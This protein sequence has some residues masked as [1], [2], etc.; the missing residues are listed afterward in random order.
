MSAHVC[1]HCVHAYV[2]E[3]RKH[4]KEAYA[5]V[6]LQ[7]N[8][9]VDQQKRFYDRA[10]STTQLMPGDIVL[11]KLDMFQGKRKVK[12]QWREVEYVVV[13]QV[14]DIDTCT[15]GKIVMDNLQRLI[16]LD[17]LNSTL[18]SDKCD[19]LFPSNCTNLN[20]Q[21]YNLIV[22]QHNVRSLLGNLAE[23]KQLLQTLHDKNSPVD[24]LLL[25][26]T[27]LTKNVGLVSI[28][29]SVK[30]STKPQGWWNYNFNKGWDSLQMKARPRR[31]YRKTYR[32]NIH[33]N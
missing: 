24:L 25:C 18:W 27:F 6:H 4:F 22:L 31:I 32:I 21:N 20:P 33:R 15:K 28:L 3:V 11:M 26:E 14:A 8:S 7:T 5:E 29:Y 1:S 12:D 16:N 10:T 19:Y 30:S 23:T 17:E 9:E 13:C 2:E